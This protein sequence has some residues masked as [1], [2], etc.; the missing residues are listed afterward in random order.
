MNDIVI[1]RSDAND[2]EELEIREQITRIL[3]ERSIGQWPQPW[4]LLVVIQELVK[5]KKYMFFD[6]PFIKSAPEVSPRYFGTF[7]GH[8]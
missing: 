2:Q 1:P 7:L 6:L 4:G 3:L 8:N 5:N